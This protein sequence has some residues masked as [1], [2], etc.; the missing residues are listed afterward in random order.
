MRKRLGSVAV[1]TL[2]LTLGSAAHAVTVTPDLLAIPVSPVGGAVAPGGQVTDQFKAFGVIFS[3]GVATAI[4][5]DPPLA[6]GG[7]N[8]GGIVDL[9]AP[10]NGAFVGPGTTTLRSV[11]F[12][13]IEA[14]FADVGSLRLD[15]FD[16]NRV[17]LGST[18]N[19]DGIGPHDRTLL[20]LNLPGITFFS[21]STP[22]G[23][24]FGVNQ[25]DF[26]GDLAPIPE[27]GTVLLLGSTLAGLAGYGRRRFF[28]RR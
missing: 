26:E 14:G 15:V 9:L 13:S 28:S 21:V 27:P 20:T 17:L 11:S 10:V 19:D 24:S 25:I 23:D 12:V 1:A 2:V 3:D 4:F 8:A 18:L 6:F 7:V 5:S 16:V 22:A